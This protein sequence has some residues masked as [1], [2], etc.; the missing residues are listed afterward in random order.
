[1]TYKDDSGETVELKNAVNGTTFLA[2]EIVKDNN[3][4]L[5]DLS[6]VVAYFGRDNKT[7]KD[8]EKLANKSNYAQYDLNRDGQ[9][10]SKDIAMVLVSWGK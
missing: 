3:I 7:E 8:N 10:D 6:A 9:I 5:Y 4:N 1:M 2:G